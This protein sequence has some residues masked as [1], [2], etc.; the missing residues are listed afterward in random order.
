[1]DRSETRITVNTPGFRS[2]DYKGSIRKENLPMNPFVY[3]LYDYQHPY[4]VYEREG[5]GTR[6]RIDGYLQSIAIPNFEPRGIDSFTRS[7]VD[8]QAL[9]KSLLD[10]KGQKVNVGVTLAERKQTS[11]LILDTAKRIG[12]SYAAAKRGN[13]KEAL[14]AVSNS[15]D[16]RRIQRNLALGKNDRETP[17]LQRANKFSASSEILAV[18]L[19]W[20][21]LLQDIFNYAELLASKAS[22]PMRLTSTSSVTHRWDGPQGPSETWQGVDAGR[23]EF[24][25]YTRKYG[26][27]F[28]ITNEFTRTLAE[29]GITNPLSWLW[30]LT[31][32]SFVADWVIRVGDFIDALDATVGL[33]FEKG[34]TTTFEKCRV[35]YRCKGSSAPAGTT[36]IQASGQHTMVEVQRTPLT[37]FPG[38]PP[39]VLGSG[40]NASRGLTAGA[41][42]RQFFKK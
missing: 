25:R 4:G 13:L 3:K 28:S 37:G 26:F 31:V 38:I 15:P 6:D 24:G 35:V 20:R 9:L 34:Y 11:N 10:L 5:G 32:L 29:V 21:P 18:Q 22:D 19:G 39:I 16:A 2:R 8:A 17:R 12:T 1:M 40:L 14:D 23:R 7:Q 33:T 30:E 36:Y 41:L 27:V 42:I